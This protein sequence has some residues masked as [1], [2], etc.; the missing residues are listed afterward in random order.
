MRSASWIWRAAGWDGI[1]PVA[2]A[3][4]PVL[5]RAVFRDPGIVAFA[6]VFVP[7]FAAM[8]RANIGRRQIVR[9]GGEP[10]PIS[11]QLGFS[12][13]I[14]LLLLFELSVGALT[15]AENEPT[16]A[17]C[18]PAT[19]FLL[20]LITIAL[21]LRP[22]AKAP[23]QVAG[24]AAPVFDLGVV[25]DAPNGGADRLTGLFPA[26]RLPDAPATGIHSGSDVFA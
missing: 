1:L 22:A 20:Y 12:A 15:C 11:R 24:M 16:A 6:A 9:V 19:I 13:A 25:S 3:S 2:V 14:V 8:L 23:I 5:V 21:A 17:W 4:V 10:P 7:V 18:I 26:V